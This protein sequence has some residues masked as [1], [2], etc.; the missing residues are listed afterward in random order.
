MQN[1]YIYKVFL[2]KK[3][4]SKPTSKDENIDCD[5]YIGNLISWIYPYFD[6]K[7]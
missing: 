3:K 5:R 6:T 7:Y 1:I 4:N 2:N